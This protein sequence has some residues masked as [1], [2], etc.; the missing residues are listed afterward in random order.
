MTVEFGKRR[1]TSVRSLEPGNVISFNYDG[2]RRI[3]VVIAP[4]YKENC[5]CFSYD[6]LEEIPEEM[7]TYIEEAN[8]QV[9]EGELWEVFGDPENRYRSF[10]KYFMKLVQ[11]V[12]FVTYDENQLRITN[13]EEQNTAG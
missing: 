5:D 8:F 7:L 13:E 4:D 6:I 9:K 3:G 12:D 2:E 1:F 10:K 11:L